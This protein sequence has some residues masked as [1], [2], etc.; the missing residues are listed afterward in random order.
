MAT[1]GIARGRRLY[2]GSG[3]AVP[4]RKLHAGRGLLVASPY[5]TTVIEATLGKEANRRFGQGKDECRIRVHANSILD[6]L[7]VDEKGASFAVGVAMDFPE[8]SVGGFPIDFGE[9]L[10]LAAF[11][12]DARANPSRPIVGIP[13]SAVR[14]DE[15]KFL[16]TSRK[17]DFDRY[18]VRGRIGV[19]EERG[20]EQGPR[21]SVSYWG[22]VFF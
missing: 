21:R 9:K 13:I 22:G 7:A 18:A 16:G 19:S 14:Y 5:R 17:I 15:N 1:W 2:L 12:H 20:F 3:A 8:T 10:L 4:D 11:Q 6:L